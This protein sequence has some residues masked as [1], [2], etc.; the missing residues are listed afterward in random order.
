MAAALRLASLDSSIEVHLFEAN[1]SMGGVLQTEQADGFC[2]ELGPDSMLS[3]LPWGMDLCRQI[4]F[5]K[6]LVS[7]HSKPGGVHV[8]CRGQLERVPDGLAIMAP[9]RIWPMVTTPILS[10][11][12]KLRLAS[13]YLIPRR[14]SQQDESLADFCCRRLG[15][16]TFERLIQPLAGGIYMGD[17]QLLGVQATFP[18]FVEMERQH[19]SLIRAVR[20]GASNG[21]ASGEPGGPQYSMFVAPRLGMGQLVNSL[22]EQLTGCQIHTNQRVECILPHKGGTWR[23]DVVDGTTANRW[24]ETF[25]GVIVA[26]PAP[27]ASPFL[28]QANPELAALLTQ[29]PYAGC[30][31]VNLAYDRETIPHPLDSFGFVGPHIER[32]SVLACTFS[33]IKYPGRAPD[34]K[35]LFRAFLGGDCFP[36]VLEWTDQRVLQVVQDE[37]RHLLGVRGQPLFSR[38][39]RWRQSMPQYHVGHLQLVEKIELR[40]KTLPGFELA[41]NSYRGVGI[42]HCIHSGEQASERLVASLASSVQLRQ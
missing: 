6:E 29:I 24:Q 34:G 39:V 13:E 30:L 12:G 8:V 22:A 3:R 5:D 15:R 36:E 11:P 18:Q 7:T 19:G 17:P 26:L 4:G 27:H 28:K 42:P 37:L 31:V 41:G 20:R 35:V 33:S 14:R 25:D 1:K 2:L 10:W 9:R 32:R 40:V 38:I 16:E 23:V 21:Q